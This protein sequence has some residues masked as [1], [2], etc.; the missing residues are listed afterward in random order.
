MSFSLFVSDGAFRP[1]GTLKRRGSTAGTHV[2]PAL[3]FLGLLLVRIPDGHQRLIRVYGATRCGGATAHHKA[4]TLSDTPTPV[5]AS[6]HPVALRP[7][8][9]RCAPGDCDGQS[10]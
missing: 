4:R 6:L 10:F 1:D 8:G 2:F 5:A 9:P 3:E 7:N